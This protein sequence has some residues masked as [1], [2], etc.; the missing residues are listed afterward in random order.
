M[1]ISGARILLV[2][3]DHKTLELVHGYLSR[4]GAVPTAVS[5]T[6]GLA[7][8]ADR[9]DIVLLFDDSGDPEALESQLAAVGHSQASLLVITDRPGFRLD[10][11]TA[12]VVFTPT[13][14][15]WGWALLDAIRTRIRAATPELPFTD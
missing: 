7:R 5:R 2:S 15:V 1:E 14:L 10:S 3:D 11:P 13:R 8:E 6:A 4:A 12:D 9:S